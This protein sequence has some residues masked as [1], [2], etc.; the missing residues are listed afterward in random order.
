MRGGVDDDGTGTT[1]QDIERIRDRQLAGGLAGARHPPQRWTKK[2]FTGRMNAHREP[3]TK[4]PDRPG[5]T[6]R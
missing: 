6:G 2:V 3:R 1:K 4:K 5:R